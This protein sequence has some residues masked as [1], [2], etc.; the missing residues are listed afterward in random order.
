M[1]LFEMIET[2]VINRVETVVTVVTSPKL[3]EKSGNK[4]MLDVE[5]VETR[6]EAE[7]GYSLRQANFACYEQPEEITE[8]TDMFLYLHASI[9]EGGPY[10]KLW[11]R[12]RAYVSRQLPK[13]L[14]SELEKVYEQNKLPDDRREADKGSPI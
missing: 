11:P 5:T 1:G 8:E 13:E 6:T 4:N 7:K 2:E 12:V 3:L 10:R 14:F 9:C